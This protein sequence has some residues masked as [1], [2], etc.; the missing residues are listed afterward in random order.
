MDFL[1]PFFKKDFIKQTYRVHD[2]SSNSPYVE[3]I[4]MPTYIGGGVSIVKFYPST[5][6]LHTFASFEVE[7]LDAVGDAVRTEIPDF[8]D[9][10]GNYYVSIYV[11]DS[12]AEGYGSISFV[13]V[14][15]ATPAGEYI[16]YDD[17]NSQGYNLII[18]K[19][20]LIQPFERN[21]S[22][23]I[24]DRPP[25][26]S[27]AQTIAPARTV[28]TVV[29]AP[30]SRVIAG[31]TKFITAS[32]ITANVEGFD[33]VSATSADIQDVNIR[34]FAMKNQGVSSTTNQVLTTVRQSDYDIQGGQ[35]LTDTN[36]FK[37]IL[38]LQPTAGVTALSSNHKGAT[39]TL[40][41][42]ND[43]VNVTRSLSPT[44]VFAKSNPYNDL[45]LQGQTQSLAT[46]LAQYTATVVRVLNSTSYIIDKPLQ[47]NVDSFN[48]KRKSSLTR[49]AT[50]TFRYAKDIKATVKHADPIYLSV[51]NTVSQSYLQFTFQDLKPIGGSVYR[52]KSF[53]R[54]NSL[55]GDYQLIN[56]QRVGYTEYLT[57]A[58]EPNRLSYAKEVSPFLLYGH[59]QGQNIITNYWKGYSETS[60]TIDSQI[61][62]RNELVLTD[63]AYLTVAT[64]T[65]T[66]VF[67]TTGYQLY[68]KDQAFS[69][70]FVCMLE[71]NTTLEVY[72]NSKPITTQ[73]YDSNP[74]AQAYL[75]SKNN[76]RSRYPQVDSRFGKLIGSI[77]NSTGERKDYGRVIFDVLADNDGYG[78]PLFRAKSTDKINTA[79]ALVSEISVTPIQRN[80]Y[81]PEIY[82]YSINAPAGFEQLI[83]ES[84]DFKFEYYDHTGKQSEY[85]TYI[86]GL[87][88]SLSSEIQG[89]VCQVENYKFIFNPTLWGIVTESATYRNLFIAPYGGSVGTYGVQFAN[90]SSSNTNLF[91]TTHS[92]AQLSPESNTGVNTNVPSYLP[93]ND[94]QYMNTGWGRDEKDSIRKAITGSFLPTGSQRRRYFPA[95]D[96]MY[97]QLS[98]YTAY[99][100]PIQSES[101]AEGPYSLVSAPKIYSYGVGSTYNGTDA[102]QHTWSG[103]N[104][105]RPYKPIFAHKWLNKTDYANAANVYSGKFIY[106]SSWEI[107][108][109]LGQAVRVNT[110]LAAG[111]IAPVGAGVNGGGGTVRPPVKLATTI[112]SWKFFDEFSE[113]YFQVSGGAMGIDNPILGSLSA[114]YTAS[115]NRSVISASYKPQ[116]GNPLGTSSI[117]L[118]YPINAGAAGIT[119]FDVSQSY[120]TTSGAFSTAQ[121]ATAYK[122][123]RFYFPFHGPMA[124]N[125]FTEN[126][127]IYNVKFRL[128]RY[129]SGSNSTNWYSPDTGSYLMV[130]IFNVSSSF[131]G[132]AIEGTPGYYPPS[133]NIIKIGNQITTNGYNIPPIQFYDSVTGY[134]YDEYELNLIQ[135]G[136]PGQ[137]VFEPSGD[138]GSYFGCAIDSVEFCKI[139][140]TTDPYYIQSP[141]ST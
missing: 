23:L 98:F 121:K 72:A 113:N 65:A 79:T 45:T 5:V 73:L 14:A 110:T 96:Q 75:T 114:Q 16:E 83:S 40:S 140:T 52:V 124:E 109:G 29:D 69:I 28:Y 84:V 127:G 13:G 47:V 92:F 58:R 10:F 93:A 4:D 70:S 24:F 123:R 60:A 49:T 46:Q 56:D 57:E 97:A 62:L 78:R 68:Q 132:T 104:A 87:N 1:Q 43:Y 17:I 130:Y 34:D 101:F 18:A 131:N 103:W 85:V 9:R 48:S 22:P 133:Q 99:S 31:N 36:R 105:L 107:Y 41:K 20:L 33:K 136:T 50:H 53:Y 54:Q 94:A 55:T 64:P 106:T 6:N 2:T 100:N 66:T 63:S 118:Q 39:I 59:F 89:N 77:V 90:P 76:E 138:P 51:S 82:Q 15:N 88:L 27:V 112:A 128:K 95:Y 80:G 141:S 42:D 81:T 44:A 21:D 108:P 35:L 71:A 111:G 3:F 129:Q 102:T 126:G 119:R 135:Y 26:V 38:Q 74:F 7:V 12:T 91:Y 139:G 32:F 19:P 134:L 67:T 86:N 61:I 115:Y 8:R 120:V 117:D 37:T 30:Q 116:P 125:V 25:Q 137:L 11:Q 122:Q